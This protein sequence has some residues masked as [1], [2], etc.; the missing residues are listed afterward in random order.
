MGLLIPK[1]SVEV[2]PSK[3]FSLFSKGESVNQYQAL[4]TLSLRK[5]D[6][7]S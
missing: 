1:T 7:V 5:G 3:S 2:A 4:A 6:F